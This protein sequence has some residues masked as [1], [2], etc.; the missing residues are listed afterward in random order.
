MAE[1]SGPGKHFPYP[2]TWGM[3]RNTDGVLAYSFTLYPDRSSPQ[4][5][6]IPTW[7]SMNLAEHTLKLREALIFGF[8]NLSLVFV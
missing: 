2:V 3:G 4:S 8:D 5:F 7:M 6:V 1:N